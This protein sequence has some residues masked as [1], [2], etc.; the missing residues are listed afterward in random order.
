MGRENFRKGH[1]EGIWRDRV[2]LGAVG[3]CSESCCW[4]PLNLSWK[5]A[6]WRVRSLE[7]S[8]CEKGWLRSHFY[9]SSLTFLFPDQHRVG[10]LGSSPAIG[11]TWPPGFQQY[12]HRP[13]W[14]DELPD[15]GESYPSAPTTSACRGIWASN[16]NGILK[17]KVKKKEGEI[18]YILKTM[19]RQ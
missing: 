18:G 16:M 2:P 14:S 7:S 17:K 11:S 3:W 10:Q 13:S 1:Y 8:V 19:E 5:Q 12:N 9:Q 6:W 4:K 15:S